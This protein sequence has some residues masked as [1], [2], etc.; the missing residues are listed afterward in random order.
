[1]HIEPRLFAF[2]KGV[3]GRIAG[4]VALGLLSVS[5]GVARL[6]LLVSLVG[7]AALFR[8]IEMEYGLFPAFGATGGL[9]YLR[10]LTRSVDNTK[11]GGASSVG[12]VVEGT[13]GGQRLLVPAI[14]VGVLG[15]AV[16][17]F[18]SIALGQTALQALWLQCAGV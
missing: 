2:T 5:L 17:T 8:W 6:G 10:L 7:A 1:M 12:E 4:T 3:R 9:V 14:L 13:L 16:A 11:P 15:Y 18:A